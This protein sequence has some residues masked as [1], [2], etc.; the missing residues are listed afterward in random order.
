MTGHRS[1][2]GELMEGDRRS[3]QKCFSVAPALRRSLPPSLWQNSPPFRCP[4]SLLFQPLVFSCWW[5]LPSWV[6]DPQFEKHS[7]SS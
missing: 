3:S 1:P 7:L 6:H 4:Y 2:W 5:H